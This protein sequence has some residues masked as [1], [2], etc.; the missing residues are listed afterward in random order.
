ML[1]QNNT[2]VEDLEEMSL[3]LNA[4]IHTLEVLQ[5]QFEI[6]E[7]GEEV[8]SSFVTLSNSVSYI[9]EEIS[10]KA[11]YLLKNE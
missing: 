3:Q 1:N 7:V 11:M 9:K 6:Q 4:L 5:S 10:K 8:I 2:H